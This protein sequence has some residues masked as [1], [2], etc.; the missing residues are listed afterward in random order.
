MLSQIDPGARILRWV[1]RLAEY[2]FTMHHRRGKTNVVADF[3]SRADCSVSLCGVAEPDFEPYSDEDFAALRATLLDNPE[4]GR[5]RISRSLWRRRHE[6]QR[7]GHGLYHAVGRE[8][9][10]VPT[11][12]ELQ[13]AMRLFHHRHGHFNGDILFE[14]LSEHFWYPRLRKRCQDFVKA[15]EA[16]SRFNMKRGPYR[17]KGTE[18]LSGIF[19]CLAIDFAGPFPKDGDLEYVIVCVETMTGYPFAK[20]VEKADAD[21]VVRFLL[22]EVIPVI[23]VPSIKLSDR[24]THFL[25]QLTRK[26]AAAYGF[27]Q[28]FSP[29]ATSSLKGKA[30]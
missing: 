25:N 7:D 4:S 22:D 3:L 5:G 21:T 23:G 18:R 9:R 19:E 1:T 20:A 16:C 29:P 14:F 12:E 6:F 15:C 24:G 13:D 17:F 8:V 10:R 26:V 27:N 30:K 28:R 11:R 2:D